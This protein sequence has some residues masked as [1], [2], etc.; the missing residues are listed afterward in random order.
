MIR[1]ICGFLV[2]ALG[3]SSFLGGFYIGIIHC[4]VGGIVDFI[5]AVKAPVVEAVPIAWALAKIIIFAQAS[6][7]AGALTGA[8][9]LFLGMA[10]WDGPK[11]PPF[12]IDFSMPHGK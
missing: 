2:I 12:K 1:V 7:T 11:A 9:L 10:I 4:W 8:G 5:N 6:I 3:V